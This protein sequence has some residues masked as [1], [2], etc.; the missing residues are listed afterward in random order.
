MWDYPPGRR[1]I[2]AQN[3][4]HMC[5]PNLTLVIWWCHFPSETTNQCRAENSFISA[6]HA[7]STVLTLVDS[8]T[9]I[10]KDRFCGA[11]CERK[12]PNSTTNWI[13]KICKNTISRGKHLTA[14]LIYFVTLK[15]QSNYW[16]MVWKRS[17]LHLAIHSNC[18]LCPVFPEGEK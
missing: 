7:L 13:Q 5:T 9:I 18:L 4:S 1:A 16:K 15:L 11:F 14:W 3:V 6:S 10:V 8:P 12:F 2:N 17:C